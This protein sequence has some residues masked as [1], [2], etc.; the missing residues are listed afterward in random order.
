MNNSILMLAAGAVIGVAG[1]LL[2][3][4]SQ[5]TQTHAILSSENSDIN[6][7]LDKIAS[8]LESLNTT[9]AD[10]QN[11]VQKY[12]Y[13]MPSIPTGNTNTAQ[14]AVTVEEKN[15]DNNDNSA[16]ASI[17]DQLQDDQK[18]NTPKIQQTIEAT[19]P[20]QVQV[21]EYHS[22]ETRLYAAAN[23]KSAN[24]S[25]LLQDADQLTP[26]QRRDLTNKAMQMI[27]NGEIS[28]TQFNPPSGS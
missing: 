21:E 13:V 20:T 14:T 11:L 26:A 27:Q 25:Q 6:I 15:I 23:N 18:S 19:P 12:T 16:Y 9:T 1:T 3:S 7:Q 24:L 17:I 10:L 2:V 5:T 8:T 4:T 28:P 22:I